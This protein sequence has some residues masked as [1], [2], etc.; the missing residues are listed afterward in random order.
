MSAFRERPDVKVIMEIVEN[1]APAER[2]YLNA[3]LL[4]LEEVVPE[5]LPSIMPA[6]QLL[7]ECLRSMRQ[8]LDSEQDLR[9]RFAYLST[10]WAAYASALEAQIDRLQNCKKQE[11]LMLQ[12][13]I[14]EAELQAKTLAFDRDIWKSQV[15]ELKKKLRTLEEGA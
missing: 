8:R 15:E 1:L 3:L 10:Q 4:K 6:A 7:A 13:E 5:Q 9:E 12:G 11:S 2:E 14:D